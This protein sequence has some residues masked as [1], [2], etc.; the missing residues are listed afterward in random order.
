MIETWK[1]VEGYEGLY[2]ISTLGNLKSLHT[3]KILKK[4]PHDGYARYA[5]YRDKKPNYI[6]AHRLVAMNYLNNELNKT[7][8]NHID[9]N[10]LNNSI[11]NL[12]WV[13]HTENMNHAKDSGLLENCSH[14]G[15]DNP[16]YKNGYYT[17][18]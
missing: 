1:D 6:L 14:K 8:V 2:E 3:N 18:N 13:T 12:E 10:K 11:S 7:E 17:N 16:N 5:L 15:V 4:R 9:G